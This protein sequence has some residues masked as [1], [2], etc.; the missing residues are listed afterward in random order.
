MSAA[1]VA[2]AVPLSTFSMITAIAI[3]GSSKGAKDTLRPLLPLTVLP[4]I[5]RLTCDV[6]VFPPIRLPLTFIALPAAVPPFLRTS[7]NPF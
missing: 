6:P 5:I 7:S 1:T 3:S 4:S 2:V